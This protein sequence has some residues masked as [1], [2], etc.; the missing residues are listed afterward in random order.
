ME[1]TEGKAQT[2]LLAGKKDILEKNG[3]KPQTSDA[4]VFAKESLSHCSRSHGF[5]SFPLELLCHFGRMGRSTH[6]SSPWLPGTGGALD[7]HP[8]AL[9]SEPQF[10][11]AVDTV[12]SFRFR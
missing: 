6:G 1:K 7:L 12:P 3:L 8:Q 11:D 10:R 4:A 9:P 2:W 5:S